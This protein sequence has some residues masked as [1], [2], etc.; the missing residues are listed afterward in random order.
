MLNQLIEDT[1]NGLDDAVFQEFLHYNQLILSG[2][3]TEDIGYDPEKKEFR[4]VLDDS[5][6]SSFEEGLNGLQEVVRK[7]LTP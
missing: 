6:A 3:E 2:L 1:D 7:E 5:K 4:V